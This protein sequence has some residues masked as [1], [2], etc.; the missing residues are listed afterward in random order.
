MIFGRRSHDGDEINDV[1]SLR[2]CCH[3]VLALFC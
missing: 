2:F 1:K 3:A